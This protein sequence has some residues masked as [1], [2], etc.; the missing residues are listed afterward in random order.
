MIS[1]RAPAPWLA[2]VVVVAAAVLAGAR[3]AAVAGQFGTSLTLVEVYATVT[4]A[5]GRPVLG[6][7]R[8]EFV[9]REDGTPRPIEAFAGGE[10][11]LSVALAIDR[12]WSMAGTPLEQARLAARRFLDELRPVDDAMVVGVSSEVET[13][14]PLSRDR[15]AQRAAVAALTPWGSTKLHDAILEAYARVDGTRGRRALLVFSD[16]NDR[17]SVAT[18]AEVVARV[19]RADVLV[20]PVVLA[21]RNSSLMVQLAAFSGGRA[22]WARKADQI[23]DAFGEI[24]RELRHQYLIGYAPPPSTGASAWRRI[25]LE[26]PGRDVRVRARPGYFE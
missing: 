4:D 12:S 5:N 6:I 18:A 26:V 8:E 21:E 20:Y 7:A 16:G 13:I 1:L 11:P 10:F 19:R 14:A 22:F 24:A 23:G 2:A 17:G 9:V 25:T 15:D 3:V